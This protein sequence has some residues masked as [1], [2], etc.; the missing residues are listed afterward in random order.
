[1]PHLSDL[2]LVPRLLR[3]HDNGHCGL[4][5]PVEFA[6]RFLSGFMMRR[7]TDVLEVMW[8]SVN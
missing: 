8:E 5:R 2:G 7:A 4:A 6:G 3:A 1:M